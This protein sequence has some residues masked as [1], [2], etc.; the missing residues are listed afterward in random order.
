[1]T[2]PENATVVLAHGAWADG[3]SWSEV[4]R[5]LA[6]QGFQVLAAPLPLTSLSDDAAALKRAIART[7]GPLIVAGHAYAG[8]VIATADD[9]RVKGLVYVAA[10]APDEGETVAEVFYRDE[11]HPLAPKLAP[12]EDGWIWMPDEGFQDAFAH[13]A[14]ADQIALSRAVQRPISVKCIQEPA[15][16]P[17]WRTRPSWFLIAEE[18]RMINPKTQHFMAGRMGASVRSFAVDHT[19]LLTAPEKVVEIIATAARTALS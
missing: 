8:A 18:D 16:K 2:S 13:R 17:A 15:P 5:P 19:P 11:P 1:M 7:R 3:S 6:K 14:T 4:I 12:D 10:L 9:E